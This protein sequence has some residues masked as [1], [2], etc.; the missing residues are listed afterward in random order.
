[1]GFDPG[2]YMRAGLVFYLIFFVSNVAVGQG[3]ASWD[4]LQQLVIGQ[5]IQVVDMKL[6]STEGEFRGFSEQS[7][8]LRRG[9]DDL[10]FARPDVLRVGARGGGRRNNALIGGTVGVLLGL[11]GGAVVDALDDVDRTDPGANSG[12][13]GGAVVGFG[14]GAGVGAAFSGYHTIYARPRQ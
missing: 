6:K 5:K 13:L 12:K 3:P 4:N 14:I 11:V 10:V 2:Y 8:S 9:K 7:I 1:V